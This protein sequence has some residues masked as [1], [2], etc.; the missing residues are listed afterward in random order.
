MSVLKPGDRVMLASY[1]ESTRPSLDADTRKVP[2]GSIGTFWGL[3]SSDSEWAVVSWDDQFEFTYNYKERFE[4]KHDLWCVNKNSLE[5]YTEKTAFDRKTF[6]LLCKIKYLDER[7]PRDKSRIVPP[8]G[9]YR[10][11]KSLPEISQVCE[12]GSIRQGIVPTDPPPGQRV[13]DEATVNRIRELLS[14]GPVRTASD[15]R[16]TRLYTT[17]L[18]R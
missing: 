7:K 4:D 5:L 9:I 10:G 16:F 12:T 2:I 8:K 15:Y 1:P 14:S 18:A 11:S 17:D 3:D 6:L 13:F